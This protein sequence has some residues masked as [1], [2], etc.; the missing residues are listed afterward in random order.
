MA[1]AFILVIAGILIASA[2]LSAQEQK[3]GEPLMFPKDQVKEHP[4]DLHMG[5][6]PYYNKGQ[7]KYEGSDETG[8]PG[9]LDPDTQYKYETTTTI[10]K[11]KKGAPESDVQQ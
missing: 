11:V 7:K 3:E 2:G 9:D 6:D 1:R 4:S 8:Y 10:K 5:S